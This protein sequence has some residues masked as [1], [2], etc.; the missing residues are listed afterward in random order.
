MKQS[1]GVRIAA[2]VLAAA[3]GA[4]WAGAAQAGTIDRVK[5]DKAVR[6]AFRE[7]APPFSFKDAKGQPAGFMVE[8]CRDVAKGLS[9]Q[10]GAGA[11]DV[12]FV[13][14]TAANRFEAIQNGQA[15][16]LCEA[17]TATLSRRAQVDFSIATYVDGASVLVRTD[18]P[19][20][21]AAL[22]G[23]KIG[24][25]AGT[26]TQAELGN[27][28]KDAGITAEVVPVKSH[29]EGLALLDQAAISAYFADR[30]ILAF[31]ASQSA[32]PQKLALANNFLTIEPYA[33]ALPHGDE[34]FRLAVD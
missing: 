22:K 31:L 20:D 26:T 9:D 30:A 10:L 18:G 24:V 6:I 4:A 33:L 16:L 21:F 7:D 25:L 3:V 32:A 23:R 17:T 5:Q 27:S 29:A 28:L 15:D 34:D 8:L 13:P 12:R 14:V 11:L 1:K 2:A 19:T